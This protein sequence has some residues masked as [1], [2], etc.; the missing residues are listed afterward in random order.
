PSPGERASQA[1]GGPERNPLGFH[2]DGWGAEDVPRAG[3]LRRGSVGRRTPAPCEGSCKCRPPSTAS[4][5]DID[6]VILVLAISR[7]S[8][9]I[10]RNST[11]RATPTGWFTV[12][13]LLA[14]LGYVRPAPVTSGSV[15]PEWRRCM[16]G[17][18]A[19]P[20]ARRFHAISPRRRCTERT[21]HRSC[22]LSAVEGSESRRS[23]TGQQQRKG[24]AGAGRRV[25]ISHAR[26]VRCPRGGGPD[27]GPYCPAAL[28]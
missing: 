7:S 13:R 8:A 1:T 26:H 4:S 22:V 10:M 5:S 21:W 16:C 17:A 25:P 12:A 18:H 6:H 24:C 15:A 19:T 11:A 20:R 23:G 27:R 3:T 28:R 14:A 9:G 2:R